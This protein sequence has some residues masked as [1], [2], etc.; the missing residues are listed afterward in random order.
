MK[1]IK[2]YIG[3]IFALVISYILIR[4]VDNYSYFGGIVSKILSLLTPFFIGA[5]IAYILS[6]LV[7]FMEKRLKLKRW[8]TILAIY[9]VTLIMTVCFIIMVVPSITNSIIDIIN[10]IPH[11]SKEVENW[12]ME[13]INNL[14]G[15]ILSDNFMIHIRDTL[16]TMIPKISGFATV[17]LDYIL[18]ATVSITTLIVNIILGLILSIYIIIDKENIVIYGKKLIFIL[19]KR[20]KANLLVDVVK[21]FNT[22]VG[23]YIVAKSI[24]SFFVGLVSFAGLALIGSKYALL[25][26]IICG[27]T[28]LIPYFGPIIGMIPTVFINVFYSTKVAIA[29]LIFLIVVQQ[30]EGNIIEPKF[31]GG[32]LGLSPILTL[33]A[34]SIGGG[35]FGILGMILSVP[36]MGVVKIYFDKIIEKYDH[37][38][39]EF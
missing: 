27:I 35:F 1:S 15:S 34:V 20:E 11:Y 39:N 7:D 17:I 29:C 8:M 6:P 9:G 26:G 2:K 28:N 18:G 36:V 13:N 23:T 37:R 5:I 25:L 12:V 32:K 31:V 33:F 38:K 16:L 3:L 19:L 22:N 4:F 10:Q 24:D 14:S 21:T 30:V